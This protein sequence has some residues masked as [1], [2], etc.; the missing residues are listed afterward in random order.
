MNLEIE[1][2]FLVDSSSA[3]SLGVFETTPTKIEQCYYEINDSVVKR[4]RRV[5]TEDLVTFIV[6]EKSRCSGMSRKEVEY[7]VS[8]GQAIT[9]FEAS[10]GDV[11]VKKRFNYLFEGLVWEIDVFEKANLGLVIAEVELISE[12]QDINLPCF[13]THEVTD[14]VRYYNHS[15]SQSPFSAWPRLMDSNKLI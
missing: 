8:E 13:V 9:Y 1:R 4:I 11:I 2:K 3:N 12:C 6:T 15:L 5:V 14:D 10:I 7:P